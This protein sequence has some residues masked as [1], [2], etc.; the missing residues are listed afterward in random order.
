M[1]VVLSVVDKFEPKL[2]KSTDHLTHGMV[3]LQGGAKMSSRK[4]NILR[5]TDV[6]NL[7]ESAAKK[8]SG[9][10]NPLI[11]LGAIKYAFLRQRM[12]GDIIF[13]PSE[14]VSIEG[15]SGPYLQYAY[16]RAHSLLS[17]VG[18][19]SS[20]QSQEIKLEPGE[21]LLGSKISEYPE[22]IDRAVS[23]YLPHQVCTYLY[24]LA[25][26]F[27]SFYEVNR[28]VGNERQDVRA[29]LVESYARVLRSGLEL[30]NIPVLDRI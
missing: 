19:L 26:V 10:S 2:A 14:S 7:T 18:N 22:V 12:G 29:K 28:I 9:K 25:Q 5:A 24:E 4:G 27:N 13:D 16:A 15:N 23:E 21:R 3:K 20:K 11:T 30:L 8:L 1:K 17:K 6:I